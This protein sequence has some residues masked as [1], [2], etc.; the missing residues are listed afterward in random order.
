MSLDLVKNSLTSP[1][2]LSHFGK[3]TRKQFLANLDSIVHS[4]EAKKMMDVIVRKIIFFMIFIYQ[5][6]Q[7]RINKFFNGLNKYE[8]NLNLEK[9]ETSRTIFTNDKNA[10]NLKK[11]IKYVFKNKFL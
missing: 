10:D 9:E 11:Q 1:K 8:K 5:E 3:T 2:I 4:P 6:N 7:T